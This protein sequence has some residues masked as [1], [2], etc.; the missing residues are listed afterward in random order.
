VQRAKIYLAFCLLGLFLEAAFMIANAPACIRC[1]GPLVANEAREVPELCR[2]CIE[3][4]RKILAPKV[5][6]P[7]DYRP[8]YAVNPRDPAVTLTS[9][10]G[11]IAI[12]LFQ[13]KAPISVE[14]FL[15]YVR[16]GRYDGML[17][18]R[19]ETYLVCTGNLTGPSGPTYDTAHM[20]GIERFPA[21]TSESG[22]GLENKRGALA[23]SRQDDD[24][25]SAQGCFFFDLV[26]AP[27]YNK[28]GT[29]PKEAGYTV[30]GQ[31]LRG[32]ELLDAVSKEPLAGAAAP[33]KGYEKMPARPFRF[34]RV[35]VT[36][37]A[38]FVGIAPVA[39]A[40]PAPA[41][42]GPR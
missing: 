2:N 20:P 22:N 31:I 5:L 35:V 26:D 28:K 30:F 36:E 25:N 4:L 42:L 18:D 7:S 23:L 37:I 40:A 32:I 39:S 29:T 10:R 41:Y 19:V 12:E 27:H 11:E 3:E 9:D 14:N 34:D 24:A 8:P 21:I 16:A 6:P 33:W 1:H 38:P 17:I 13:E 15:R